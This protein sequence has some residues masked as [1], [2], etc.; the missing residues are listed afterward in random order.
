MPEGDGGWL[1]AIPTHW[2]M[3]IDCLLIL[4][5]FPIHPMD[6]NKQVPGCLPMSVQPWEAHQNGVKPEVIRLQHQ[7]HDCVPGDR[8]N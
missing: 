7:D 3:Q 5:S 6:T 4:Q 1:A 8:A 2:V